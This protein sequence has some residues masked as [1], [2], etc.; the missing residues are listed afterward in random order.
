MR[1]TQTL[2]RLAVL[3]AIALLAV[4][5]GGGEEAADV[6][7]TEPV[8]LATEETA[9]E[10]ETATEPAATGTETAAADGAGDDQLTL[11]YLLPETGQ[12]A[13]LGPPQIEAT[14]FAVSEINEAG[15]VLGNEIPDV[16]GADTAGDP[17]VAGQ[18]ADRLL[19]QGVD[20]IIGAAASGMS[21]AV[22]DQITGAEVV[23][24]SGSNT[25]PTFTDYDDGGYYFRT[26]PTDALQGPVL[27][28]TIVADG[29]SNVAILARADDYGQGLADATEAALEESGAT[30]A[31]KVIYDPNATNF[32]AAVQE[33]AAANP[34]AVALIAFEEGAQII[35]TMIE[36]GIGPETIGLYGADGLRAAELP[37]L[38]AEGD[39]GVLAGMKGTA[40]A[41]A[42]DPG[43]IEA[44]Q[45]FAP[46]LSETTFAGQV[47]DCVNLIALAAES[48]GSVDPTEFSGEIV[49]VSR[50]GTTCSSFEEC[51]ALLE[52]GDDIDYTGASGP[53]DFIDV[54]E[55]GSGTYEVWGFT[56]EGEL[57]SLSTV[58]SVRPEMQEG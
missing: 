20:A 30:V 12:L 4:A 50:E 13:F 8:D 11:G 56:E 18:S 15:G 24:C 29:F 47:Y 16:I 33:V 55:P 58:E 10:T 41:P 53:V 7:E 28:D 39:P 37:N 48:A 45:E 46:D 2:R 22:I 27:A 3:A 9:T 35:Q 31:A 57:E 32:D 54:G 52:E 5:C 25:A 44:L 34:D 14:N 51:K 38:V 36:Q 40:P 6:V 17:T 19:S 1:R 43:F 23:Q 49:N 21:L 42:E 26:A